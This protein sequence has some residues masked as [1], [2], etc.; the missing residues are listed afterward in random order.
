MCP[1]S[2]I[3]S[4]D[5]VVNVL[6]VL[7]YYYKLYSNRSKINEYQTKLFFETTFCVRKLC[8]KRK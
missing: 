4:E 5:T 2:N 7:N 6:F 3:V 8:R 1:F